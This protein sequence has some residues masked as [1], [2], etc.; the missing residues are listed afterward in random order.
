MMELQWMFLSDEWATC[1]YSI[2]LDGKDIVQQVKFDQSFLGVQK[3][4]SIGEPLLDVLRLF[5]SDKLA[6]G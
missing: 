4:C 6:M 1:V 2:G 5:D 3:W